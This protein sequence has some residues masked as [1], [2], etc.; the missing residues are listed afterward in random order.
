MVSGR[1]GWVLIPDN[2]TIKASQKLART[3][4]IPA[5]YFVNKAHISLFHGTFDDISE[6]LIKETLKHLSVL[7]GKVFRL[8]RISS[9]ANNFLFWDVEKPYPELQKAHEYVMSQY[10]GLVSK[11]NE[12]YPLVHKFFRPHITLIYSSKGIDFVSEKF[13]ELSIKKAQLT[14][15]SK[16]KGTI[17]KVLYTTS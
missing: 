11:G 7:K 6:E 5:E 1:L 2:Q 4:K 10:E 13:W 12:A 17:S 3:F 15:I 16:G 9:F 14:T 8:K